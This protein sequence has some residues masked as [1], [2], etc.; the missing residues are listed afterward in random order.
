M[1]ESNCYDPAS[2]LTDQAVAYSLTWLHVNEDLNKGIQ[3]QGI[4]NSL[5]SELLNPALKLSQQL[6][7]EP[8]EQIC[9][10]DQCTE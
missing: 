3:C 1:Q 10:A 5:S 6:Y 4:I 2:D 7:S 8:P 9:Q